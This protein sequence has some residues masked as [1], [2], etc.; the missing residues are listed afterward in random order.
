[1]PEFKAQKVSKLKAADP[2]ASYSVDGT[3]GGS[4]AS[5]SNKKDLK[6]LMKSDAKVVYD[7][8]IGKLVFK[9]NGTAEGWGVKKVGGLIDKS[10]GKPELLPRCR[11]SGRGKQEAY[12]FERQ[13]SVLLWIMRL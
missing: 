9:E 12:K 11:A 4:F 5:A 13:N 2:N 6:Q 3:G 8:K 10:K 7:E 1:M